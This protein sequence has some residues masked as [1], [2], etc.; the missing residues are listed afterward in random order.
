MSKNSPEGDSNDRSRRG[1][2]DGAHRVLG[3]RELL[4]DRDHRWQVT[5]KDRYE[6]GI[7]PHGWGSVP[8][9]PLASRVTL[10]LTSLFPGFR[11]LSC[12]LID[13]AYEVQGLVRHE[14]S[15]DVSC[16]CLLLKLFLFLYAQGLGADGSK[17]EKHKG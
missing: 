10:G 13:G 15:I 7:E 17:W 6:R 8:A 2:G 12:E 14:H 3:R 1:A 9:L 11:T 16:P 5:Q 4:Y